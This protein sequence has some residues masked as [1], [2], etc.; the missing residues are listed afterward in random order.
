MNVT[1]FIVNLIEEQGMTKTEAAN[2]CGMSR[3]NLWDKLNNRNPR[4]RSVYKILRSF[5]YNVEVL[6]IGE[7]QH[8]PDQEAF[9]ASAEK[10]NL[11][12]DSME[13]ILLAMGYKINIYQ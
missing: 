12:F 7:N 8:V 11:P 13:R 5:G 4:F 2:I 3:Q 1:E 6:P 9:I 10:E